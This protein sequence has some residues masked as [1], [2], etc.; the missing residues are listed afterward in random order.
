[1]NENTVWDA[2]ATKRAK[3][4]D[5]EREMTTGGVSSKDELFDIEPELVFSVGDEPHVGLIAIVDWIRERIPRRKPIVY[6]EDRDA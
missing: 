3:K 6:T 1:M 4:S 5:C 2:E